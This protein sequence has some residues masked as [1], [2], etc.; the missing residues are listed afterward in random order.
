MPHLA[1]RNS[2]YFADRAAHYRRLA[3]VAPSEKIAEGQL[4]LANMFLQICADLRRIE[5]TSAQ[6]AEDAANKPA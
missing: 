6:S 2:A 1:V 3:A 5:F 4:A